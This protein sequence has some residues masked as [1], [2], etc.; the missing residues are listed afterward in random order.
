M[1]LCLVGCWLRAATLPAALCRHTI[2]LQCWH[3]NI[4]RW[5]VR[6]R[7][8]CESVV[9]FASTVSVIL[10]SEW[11]RLREMDFVSI[12]AV[13]SMTRWVYRRARGFD[14]A[15]GTTDIAYQ[16]RIS[17]SRQQLLY[18]LHYKLYTGDVLTGACTFC[19][20][21]VTCWVWTKFGCGRLLHCLVVW[22]RHRVPRFSVRRVR[23]KTKHI[24]WLLRERKREWGHCFCDLSTGGLRLFILR[25]VNGTIPTY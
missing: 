21:D 2:L 13:S 5:R 17:L 7:W 23:R 24:W 15:E 12:M 10:C 22:C 16:S 1:L 14:N 20:L 3:A 9:I 6:L 11:I 4:R 8:T 18:V 19:T 25:A